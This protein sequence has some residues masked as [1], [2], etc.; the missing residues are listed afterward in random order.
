M[1]LPINSLISLLFQKLKKKEFHPGENKKL[2]TGVEE[3]FN[4]KEM[5]YDCRPLLRDGVKMCVCVC[6][7]LLCIE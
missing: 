7:S 4:E 6:L 1:F 3:S 2:K 5:S